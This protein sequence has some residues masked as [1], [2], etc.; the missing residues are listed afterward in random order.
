MDQ[1]PFLTPNLDFL[2]CTNGKHAL[3]LWSSQRLKDTVCLGTWCNFPFILTV[4]GPKSFVTSRAMFMLKQ[5]LLEIHRD[6]NCKVGQFFD[7]SCTGG[8]ADAFL[9]TRKQYC[10]LDHSG[11]SSHTG[12]AEL[13]WIRRTSLHLLQI[14][15]WACASLLW[16]VSCL[17]FVSPI[18]ILSLDLPQ[19]IFFF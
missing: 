16:V 4:Q 13:S 3:L 10:R 6:C 12:S 11:R 1:F 9:W 17:S 7:G 14:C 5:F 19:S 15:P 8:C 2:Y 18:C